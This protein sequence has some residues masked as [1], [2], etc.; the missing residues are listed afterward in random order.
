MQVDTVLTLEGVEVS[1]ARIRENTT[2]QK[3]MLID[4]LLLKNHESSNLG[5]I[6]AKGSGIQIKSYNSGGLSSISFRGTS[7]QHT[8]IYWQGFNLNQMNT[9]MIDLSLIPV[10]GFDRV[11]VLPGGGSSLFGSGN[12]GGSI[13]L[14]SEP[15]FEKEKLVSACAAAGSFGE[16]EATVANIIADEKW[17]SKTLINYAQAEN[18]FEYTDFRGQTQHLENNAYSRFGAMQD[19]Y[20]KFRRSVLGV[21]IW[22]ISMDREITPSMVEV[23]RD[24]DQFDLSFRGMIS[25]L[26]DLNDKGNRLDIKSGYFDEEYR[27]EEKNTEGLPVIETQIK[28]RK[29]QTEASLRLVM[30]NQILK[31]GLIGIGEFGESESWNGDV[32]RLRGGAYMLYTLDIPS[33]RWRTSVNLR[34]EIVEG[35]T[36]PFTPSIG[37][38]GAILK[39]LSGKMN[40]SRNFRIPTFNELFWVPGGNPE[41]KPEDSWNGESSLI[42][43]PLKSSKVLTLKATGTVYSS[44]V[45]DWVLWVPVSTWSEPRNIQDVWA[46]GVESELRAQWEY[47]KMMAGISGGYTFA[48]STVEEKSLE[49][50]ASYHKQLI[51]VPLH[52]FFANVNLQYR[53]FS[54]SYNHRFNGMVYTTSDNLESLPGFQVGE[55]NLVKTFIFGKSKLRLQADIKNVW[56]EDYQVVQNYP[57]PGRNFKI[58]VKYEIRYQ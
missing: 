50:D 22:Y 12:I 4:S 3:V 7:A 42:F 41:L 32:S 1:S 43:E 14:S 30:N 36:I 39:W 25:Y 44:W 11:D 56:D 47:R 52:T 35:Y 45:H 17:F 33:I 31:T 19:L 40:F 26:L 18:D 46:R 6:L 5:E 53:G 34:Q 49:N 24:I 13:H 15:V 16:Y 54:L 21:S 2:G 23:P 27:Y 58:S 10:S 37:A 8:G 28:T 29:S 38:E 55:F 9:G 51:Y 57:N 48:K 20:R